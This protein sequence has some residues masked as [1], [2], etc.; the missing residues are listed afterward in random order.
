M[1]CIECQKEIPDDARVC[2]YCGTIQTSFAK[3]PEAEEANVKAASEQNISADKPSENAAPSSH[4]RPRPRPRP[5]SAETITAAET[6]AETSPLSARRTQK[7]TPE[8][9]TL[10]E[11]KQR[12][13]AERMSQSGRRPQRSTTDSETAPVE[14]QVLDKTDVKPLSDAQPADAPQVNEAKAPR[15]NTGALNWPGLRPYI[16]IV[17]LAVSA[18]L[19]SFSWAGVSGS[20]KETLA[21]LVTTA[22]DNIDIID[23]DKFSDRFEDYISSR[24]VRRLQEETRQL[25]V[26]CSGGGLSPFALLADGMHLS[27]ISGIAK[28]GV[29]KLAD[30]YR[31][32][33]AYKVNENAVNS[34]NNITRK[35]KT[36]TIL[37]GVLLGL[38]AAGLILAGIG[39]LK[40]KNILTVPYAVLIIF[41]F[42]AFA[43]I[44]VLLGKVDVSAFPEAWFS[45][46]ELELIDML[47]YVSLKVPAILSLIFAAAG[48]VLAF[49]D[50]RKEVSA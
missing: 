43:A 32:N 18:I 21:S 11:R 4:L 39:I 1:L 8:R 29:N 27:R 15:N 41:I 20:D 31:N 37:W 48:T 5:G 35:I 7:N 6:P 23:L 47:K 2:P 40:K 42:A 17:L 22:T 46:S 50:S 10:A 45:R 25:L 49:L 14:P 28:Q 19:L 12:L 3:D 38:T 16:A 36:A 26:N 24:D 13:A 33:P 34:V 30:A 9:M 44:P